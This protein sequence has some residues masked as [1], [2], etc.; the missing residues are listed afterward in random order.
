MPATITSPPAS[1]HLLT[2]WWQGLNDWLLRGR[3][4]RQDAVGSAGR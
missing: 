1:V 2:F 4:G 3:I